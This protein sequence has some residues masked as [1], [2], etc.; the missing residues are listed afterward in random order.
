[1]LQ[2]SGVERSEQQWRDLIAP[3]GLKIVKIWKQDVT[4]RGTK[5]LIEC[6]RV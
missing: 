5:A 2:S 6:T 4:P 1:M 3:T